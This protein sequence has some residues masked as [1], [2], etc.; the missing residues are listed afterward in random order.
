[1]RELIKEFVKII[2]ETIPIKEPIVEFGALQVK[3]QED[4]ANLRPFFSGKK[5][6][7]ADIQIGPGVDIIL[8]LHEI[9]LPSKSVGT[10]LIMDTL[11]HVEFPGKAIEQVHRILKPNGVLV[12]SSVMNFPIHNHPHDYWRFTPEGFKSLMKI[13]TYSLVD[14]TGNDKFP[15]TI[16]GIGFKGAIEEDMRKIL[17]K[18]IEIWKQR[19]YEPRIKHLTIRQFIKQFIPPITLKLYRALRHRIHTINSFTTGAGKTGKD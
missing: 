11:E 10:V 8:N 15:H 7:G 14:S 17:S 6:I 5:Y 2:S 16:I 1:M 18:R 12:I 3:G 19:W 4:W 9:K 13:F